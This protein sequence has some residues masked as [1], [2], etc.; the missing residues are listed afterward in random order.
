MPAVVFLAVYMK[1]SCDVADGSDVE[2]EVIVAPGLADN[3]A[4]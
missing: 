1:S 2:D 3:G 4:D